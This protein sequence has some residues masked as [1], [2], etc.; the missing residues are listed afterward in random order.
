MQAFESHSAGEYQFRA[1]LQH[2]ESGRIIAQAIGFMAIAQ[3]GL[4]YHLL[5]FGNLKVNEIGAYTFSTSVEPQA[6]PL[7]HSFNISLRPNT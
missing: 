7:T 5:R 6:E 4:S 3:P 1:T 2:L